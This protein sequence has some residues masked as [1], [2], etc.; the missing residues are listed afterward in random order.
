MPLEIKETLK[1]IVKR[2]SSQMQCT[3]DLDNWEP[4]I[5]T[6]HS[7]VCQIHKAAKEI[8]QCPQTYAAG[9]I[10]TILGEN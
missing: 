9:Y 8:Y 6:G 10:P 2:I 7:F 5:S 3:C 1:E 4:E